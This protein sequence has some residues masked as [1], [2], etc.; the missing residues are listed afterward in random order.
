MEVFDRFIIGVYNY[1][2]RWCE[3]CALTNRCRL[4]ADQTE[5]EFEADHGALTE[6][7]STREERKLREQ[8]EKGPID[9]EQFSMDKAAVP[10]E[11]ACQLPPDLESAT[12]PDPYVV[13]NAGALLRK[14]QHA[15]RSG[16][17]VVRLAMETIDHFMIFVPMKMMRAL[18]QAASG[19]AREIQG[20]ANGSGKAAL[21]GLERMRGCG[22]G[23][24]IHVI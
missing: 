2:D 15:R 5:M 10:I 3:R 6:P 23:S 1:C 20:D 12:S 18:S 16:N 17:P 21:L 7:K 9:L 14:L 22:R 8:F 13:M 24:S 19:A 11:T 4:F